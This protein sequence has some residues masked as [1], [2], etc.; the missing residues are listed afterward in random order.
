PP[1]SRSHSPARKVLR[2]KPRRCAHQG[3]SS[4]ALKSVASNSAILFSNPSPFRSENGRLL[5]SEQTRRTLSYAYAEEPP[6]SAKMKPSAAARARRRLLA[7]REDIECPA[8]RGF[9]RQ[10]L[11]R[12]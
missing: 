2:T 5:G 7:Q 9:V 12:I 6:P 11:H 1:S 4:R 8:T 10:I 3:Y